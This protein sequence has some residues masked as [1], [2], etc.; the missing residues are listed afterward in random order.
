M[1]TEPVF[2]NSG[3]ISVTM[4]FEEVLDSGYLIYEKAFLPRPDRF[5]SDFVAKANHHMFPKA[6][7][8]MD[9]DDVDLMGMPSSRANIEMACLAQAHRFFAKHYGK[10]AAEHEKDRQVSPRPTISKPST[11]P[12]P[13]QEEV[14]AMAKMKV[15]DQPQ[16]MRTL[17]SLGIYKVSD[18]K[19]SVKS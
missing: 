11:R 7:F 3:A 1:M 2:I 17:S 12:V 13:W 15:I 14:M 9:V 4:C 19:L 10:L 18:Q 8:R 5:G 6:T 16:F